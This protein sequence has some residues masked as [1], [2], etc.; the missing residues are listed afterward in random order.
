MAA[1]AASQYSQEVLVFEKDVGDLIQEAASISTCGPAVRQPPGQKDGR[2]K[3]PGVP[4]FQQVHMLLKR[5]LD[6]LNLELPQ[7]E[8]EMLARGAKPVDFLNDS[9]WFQ[10]GQYYP[11]TCIEEKSHGICASRDLY[12]TVIRTLVQQQHA[13]IRFMLGRRV[14]DVAF[15]QNLGAITGITTDRESFSADLVVDA[16]GRH[17]QSVKW[18]AGHGVEGPPADEV[19][20]DLL[21][22]TR[23]YHHMG[24]TI[25][26]TGC[27][28]MICKDK[29]HT[30]IAQIIENNMVQVNLSGYGLQNGAFQTNED[31]LTFA[32]S[33]SCPDIYNFISKLTPAT[34]IQLY[35]RRTSVWKR[36]EKTT[37]PDGLVYI[38]EAVASFNPVYGQGMTVSILEA[39][40][41][42]NCLAG[43]AASKDLA[44][45][46]QE[47]HGK[48]P[49]LVNAA[50]RLS[51][52]EDI[53][54]NAA[55]N[56]C[57]IEDQWRKHEARA[58]M[59]I[60]QWVP[61]VYQAL[62]K[63]THLIA[64]NE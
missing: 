28:I 41:L 52:I 51:T 56:K 6:V 61:K 47:F 8:K 25:Q 64:G 36:F 55:R 49:S 33:L 35:K 34:D 21:Y 13:N 23:L 32:R 31:Y 46:P 63:T 54:R 7:F 17:S 27:K 57:T 24:E 50:W 20:V 62:F 38:G 60:A 19:V 15:D 53:P 12:E 4:Q 29:N 45:L 16:S 42:N 14:K 48:I 30:G 11:R 18:L 43:R 10:F 1:H 5:G 22:G 40:E 3:R 59:K 44:G 2:S 37:L 58:Y 39:L 26:D 9:S